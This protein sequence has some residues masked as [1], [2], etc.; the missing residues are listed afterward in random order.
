MP[1]TPP[2]LFAEDSAKGANIGPAG[3]QLLASLHFGHEIHLDPGGT[4]GALPSLGNGVA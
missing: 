4:S 2:W 3:G 1:L